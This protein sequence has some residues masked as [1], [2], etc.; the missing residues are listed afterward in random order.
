MLRSA[1]RLLRRKDRY[2]RREFLAEGRQ[3]VAEALASP[4]VV[5]RLLIGQTALTAHTDLLDQARQAGVP[6]AAAPEP[7]FGQL[8]DTAT[9]QG[10]IAVCRMGDI[11][12]DEAV[13]ASARLVVLA[14]RVRDPG[15]LGTMIRCA[16]AFGA[17]AVLVSTD[18]VD[19]YNPKTVR[20]STGS[21]FHL[22]VAVGVD[23]AEAVLTA[24][25]AGLAVLGADGSADLLLDDLADA[26]GLSGPTL[27]VFGNEAWGLPADQAALLDRLVA[28]PIYGRAESLNLAAAAAVLLHATAHAQ[29]RRSLPPLDNRRP[30][31]AA[32][33]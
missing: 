21:V 33:S 26:G 28:V 12:L 13:P 17:D 18:S 5:S 24:R 7:D 30:D 32:S 2:A 29:R 25:T 23:L 4:G 10:V 8:A 31:S 11:G 1:R 16:D 6:V 22:P 27:W 3:A 15:N 20:A 9:P 14:H 19:V